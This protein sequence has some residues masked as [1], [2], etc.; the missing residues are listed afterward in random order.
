MSKMIESSGGNKN[1]RKVMI[2]IRIV[3]FPMIPVY[4]T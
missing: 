3:K 4:G 1:G 2:T